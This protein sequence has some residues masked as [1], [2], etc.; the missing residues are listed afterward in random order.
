V[1]NTLGMAAGAA[2]VVLLVSLIM[3]AHASGS[4]PAADGAGTA[5][6]QVIQPALSPIQ[7][8]AFDGG[9]GPRRSRHAPSTASVGPPVEMEG[10]MAAGYCRLQL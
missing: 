10:H 5:T 7:Q 6:A 4:S 3:A 8:L 9:K 1:R 2:L